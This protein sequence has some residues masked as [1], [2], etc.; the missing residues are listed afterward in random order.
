M[1]YAHRLYRR[2]EFLRQTGRLLEALEQ[3]ISY[4]RRPMASL[5]QTL[6]AVEAF[7]TF[8]LVQD[9]AA[10]LKQ[11]AFSEAF[12]GAV[13]RAVAAG[14]LTPVPQ[15]ILLEFGGTCGRLGLEQQVAHIRACRQQVER[16]CADARQEAAARGQVY[17]ML[18]LSGGIGLA[19]LLL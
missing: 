19:L 12:A 11:A 9:T 14:L 17:R 2:A 16:A 15:Q 4:S 10:G 6:A 3:Q 8:S 5:W 7:A 18:G 1:Y 13:N